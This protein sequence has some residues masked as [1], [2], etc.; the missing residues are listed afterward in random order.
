MGE[1]T[2]L[3]LGTFIGSMIGVFIGSGIVELFYMVKKLKEEPKS[4][5]PYWHK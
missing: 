5:N 2:T 4:N 1:T 3:L